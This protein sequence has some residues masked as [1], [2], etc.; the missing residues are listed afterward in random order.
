MAYNVI[1]GKMHGLVGQHGD[2]EIEGIKVFK[3]Y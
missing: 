3:M 2:Q 1:K